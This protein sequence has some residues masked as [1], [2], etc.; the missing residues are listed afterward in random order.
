MDYLFQIST[1]YCILWKNKNLLT[2]DSKSQLSKV[3]FKVVKNFSGTT[4]L[5]EIS[6]QLLN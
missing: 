1:K 4:L 2:L 3:D 5:R 6:V